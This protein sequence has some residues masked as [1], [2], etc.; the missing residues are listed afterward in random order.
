MTGATQRGMAVISALLVATVVAVIVAAMLARQT[1]ITRS[2]ESENQRVQGAWLSRGVLEWARQTLWQQRLNDP[3][4]RLDQPWAQPLRGLQLGDGDALFDGTLSD[5]QGKFNLR[6]LVQDGQLDPVELAAFE[7][8]CAE[9]GVSA[10]QSSRMVQRVLEAYPRRASV[11]A[12]T[13]R[14]V[15]DSDLAQAPTLPASRPMLRH[16]QDL[17]SVPGIDP[18]ALE[19]LRP[20]ITVLPANTWVNG[21][22]ASAQVIAARVPGM[23]LGRAQEVVAER[24]RGQWF[25]NAGDY[26]N[27]LR[28]PQ[29]ST[30]QLRL[31][32]TSEWFLLRGQST[33]AR[34]QF[35]VEALLFRADL[36]KPRVVWSRV[37]A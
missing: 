36:A 8:L 9:L 13:G 24:D 10:A 2:V 33:V 23:A 34:R 35:Q 27:R 19:R 4:T 12:Q 26:L 1:Q 29:M 6:N 32:I 16:V 21:N 17:A 30:E 5:E 22:T 15:N 3:M 18:E 28:L 11:P 31:G 7:R 25:I 37:G 20:F 14:P